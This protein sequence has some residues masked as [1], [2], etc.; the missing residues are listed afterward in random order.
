MRKL[1]ISAAALAL[2]GA[3]AAAATFTVTPGATA[4]IPN[5]NDFKAELNALGLDLFTTLGALLGVN[6]TA[7][8]RVNFHYM[9]SE[10]GFKD[11][12]SAGSVS[13]SENNSDHFAAPKLIGSAVFNSAGD[14]NPT[15]TSNGNA[16]ISTP[17]MDSFGIFLPGNLQG[18]YESTVVYFGFDDQINNIDDNHDDFIVRATISAI[19]EPT[20][21]AMMIGGLGMIGLGVRRRAV[22]QTVVTA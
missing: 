13:G 12:F 19:P 14:F 7:P 16:L 22:R 21:W 20:T 5:N 10:S 18:A 4:A 8:F 1:L 9:G 3:P 6:A 15:F 17:G 2:L 11:T